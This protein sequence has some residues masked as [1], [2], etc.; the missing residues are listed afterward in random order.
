MQKFLIAGVALLLFT[1]G[2][3][4]P[5]NSN[6]APDSMMNEKGVIETTP[7]MEKTGETMAEKNNGEAMD[8]DAGE[9]MNSD[10]PDAM[11]KN[12]LTYEPF[13]LSAYNEARSQGKTIFL[14]FYAN[15]CPICKAQD[16]AL[17][18]GLSQLSGEKWVAFQVNYKD[19]DTDA[20]EEALAR[21]FNITYQ[22]THIV[23]DA[24][25]TI[26]LRSNEQW[27]S[28]DVVSALSSV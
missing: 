9:T 24:S 3:V 13:T 21:E 22:H 5:T 11:M 23:T 19:S 20:D 14:E 17:R 12:A 6:T 2:C 25:G 7:T 10:S 16:P 28:A 4:S 18:E 8:K 27:S 15:W 26:K 1:L